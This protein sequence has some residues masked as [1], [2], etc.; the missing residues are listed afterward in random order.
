MTITETQVIEGLLRAL[1]KDIKAGIQMETACIDGQT[2]FAVSLTRF[3][4]M[5]EDERISG[6]RPSQSH[7]YDKVQDRYGRVRRER[8][9]G[10]NARLASMWL[11][12]H[13][14]V[15]SLGPS[16][17]AYYSLALM[18]VTNSTTEAMYDE[19]FR[20]V[21]IL[22]RKTAEIEGS[23]LYDRDLFDRIRSEVRGLLADLDRYSE[24]EG[25]TPA[26]VLREMDYMMKV[27]ARS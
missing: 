13:K 14:A 8:G 19:V 6:Y 16:A 9:A 27:K 4:R 7:W 17:G 3:S 18:S 24:S 25:G 20:A 26:D 22:K 11:F 1:A 10:P 12:V 2:A 23:D 15:D 21:A 5:M